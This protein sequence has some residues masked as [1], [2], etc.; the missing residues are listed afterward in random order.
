MIFVPVPDWFPRVF[1]VGSIFCWCVLCV[2]GMFWR[3]FEVSLDVL[4]NPDGPRKW[5]D[6]RCDLFCLCGNFK[7][8]SE[9]KDR[10][11]PLEYRFLGSERSWAAHFWLMIDRSSE[12]D[13]AAEKNAII[14]N[15]ISLLLCALSSRERTV[16]SFTACTSSFLQVWTPHYRAPRPHPLSDNQRNKSIQFIPTNHFNSPNNPIILQSISLTH[17]LFDKIPWV[18]L[19]RT[20][21][22]QKWTPI[23]MIIIIPN[24]AQMALRQFPS[25]QLIE[26]RT[27]ITI[28]LNRAHRA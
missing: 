12:A 2:P 17:F 27:G 3:F 7:K 5:W 18:L 24:M 23:T 25:I 1:D 14:I 9:R 10:N 16:I 8:T 19:E 28:I 15:I 22:T 26:G 4:T 11:K 20:L 6:D 13:L 21:H